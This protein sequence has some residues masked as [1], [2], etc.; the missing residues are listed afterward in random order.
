MDWTRILSAV[1]AGT[2]TVVYAISPTT[3]QA[4]RVVCRGVG[5][6]LGDLV[7]CPF[8]NSASRPPL[9]EDDLRR[10][11]EEHVRK[12]EWTVTPLLN[13]AGIT[14]RYYS[15]TTASGLDVF[16]KMSAAS[17]VM[18]VVEAASGVGPR[19]VEFYNGVIPGRVEAVKAPILQ[20]PKCMVAGSSPCQSRYVVVLENL[21]ACRS[22]S[23]VG[24]IGETLDVA[25]VRNAL[26]ALARFHAEFWDRPEILREQFR[27]PDVDFFDLLK[28]LMIPKARKKGAITSGSAIDRTCVVMERLGGVSGLVEVLNSLVPNATSLVHGDAHVGNLYFGDSNM[29]GLL[30]WQTYHMGNPL[31][32][33]C[34]MLIGS[35][36]FE[37]FKQHHLNLSNV[38][39]SELRNNGIRGLEIENVQAALPL[40]TA[41][42]VFAVAMVAAITEADASDEKFNDMLAHM[43]KLTDYLKVADAMEAL[44]AA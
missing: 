4:V 3:R 33:V 23:K 24:Q 42:F 29:V 7:L 30:D 32:D 6:V 39:L 44:V 21:K 34:G 40:V 18:R 12:E 14:A 22:V 27:H 19:E 25:L 9:N 28:K 35:L 10:Y 1:V 20:L 13:T 37:D 31:R 16:V 17:P 8:A 15:A 38:Y 2:A 11:L 5:S 26:K 36:S 43:E 41:T